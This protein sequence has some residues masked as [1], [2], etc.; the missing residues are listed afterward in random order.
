VVDP[1]VT[2]LDGNERISDGD[3]DCLAIVDMG[4]Y[5][6]FIPPLQEPFNAEPYDG[7]IDV[8]IDTMLQW[9][10]DYDPP[11]PDPM[12]WVMVPTAGRSFA[13]GVIA[14]AGDETITTTPNVNNETE[15][16]QLAGLLNDPFAYDPVN[17]TSPM[18]QIA[19]ESIKFFR[20]TDTELTTIAY[21]LDDTYYNIFVD[22]YGRQ[23]S[24]AIRLA[25]TLSMSNFIWQECFR[26]RLPEVSTA[27]I[28][29]E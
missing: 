6:F 11:T 17:P 8:S 9:N 15:T 4:A 3:L 16:V 19:W 25:M 27:I 1:N 12:T 22:L 26:K 10:I 18:P 29:F 28:M 21:D 2:D 5:E 23:G 20:G 14:L 24:A 7:T 13:G